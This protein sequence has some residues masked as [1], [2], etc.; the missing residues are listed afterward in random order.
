MVVEGVEHKAGGVVD[1][2]T[3]EEDEIWKKGEQQGLITRQEWK[4]KKVVNE[5][6]CS[7]MTELS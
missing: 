2:E 5:L 1:Y 6:K 3:E 7:E 4:K